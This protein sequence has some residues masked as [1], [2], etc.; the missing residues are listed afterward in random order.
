MFRIETKE[1]TLDGLS[2]EFGA[3]MRWKDV[4]DTPKTTKMAIGK[5]GTKKTLIASA[6]LK[7]RRG[8]AIYQKNNRRNCLSPE[9]RSKHGECCDAF[10]QQHHFGHEHRT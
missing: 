3:L 10:A 8:L 5:R 6:I 1:N 4:T 9:M 7:N 2:D